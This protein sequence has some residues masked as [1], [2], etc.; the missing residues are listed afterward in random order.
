MPPVDVARRHGFHPR[1]AA[2][3]GRLNAGELVYAITD[4]CC[5]KIGKSTG[6][7]MTRLHDLQTGNPRPLALLAYTSTLSE[8]QAH[9][10]LSRWRVH[11]EWFRA[12]PQLLQELLTWDWCDLDQL[13]ALRRASAAGTIQGDEGRRRQGGM[14]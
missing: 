10:R 4:G 3:P 9:R 5:V 13:G 14:T 1:V 11:G 8:K 12:T 7:P 6:H 2:D